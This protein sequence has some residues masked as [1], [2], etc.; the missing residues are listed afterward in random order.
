VSLVVI[1]G[2]VEGLWV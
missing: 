2:N 1:G